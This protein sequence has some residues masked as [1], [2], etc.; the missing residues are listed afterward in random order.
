MYATYV[1]ATQNQL[2][3]GERQRYYIMWDYIACR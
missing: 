3:D 2:Y 1:M